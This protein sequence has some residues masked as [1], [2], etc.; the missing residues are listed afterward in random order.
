MPA[1]ALLGLLIK[2][3]LSF[4]IKSFICYFVAVG[5]HVLWRDGEAGWRLQRLLIGA[6]ENGKNEEF[7]IRN[8]FFF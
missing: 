2:S 1:L 3:V 8:L 4:A 5:E 6:L 7:M